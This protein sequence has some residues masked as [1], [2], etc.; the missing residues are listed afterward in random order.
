MDSRIRQLEGCYQRHPDHDASL[1][2]VVRQLPTFQN[3]VVARFSSR[4]EA[5]THLGCLK[6][7]HPHASFD[8]MFDAVLG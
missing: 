1:W 7:L 2:C 5:E 4:L 6:R 3:I 8:L